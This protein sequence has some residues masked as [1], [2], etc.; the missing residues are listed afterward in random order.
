MT[1]DAQLPSFDDPPVTEVVVALSFRPLTQL[2]VA[3]LG[4][5]WQQVLA[6]T[7]PHIEERPPYEPPVERFDGPVSGGFSLRVGS[8][9]PPPRL[10]FKSADDQE[11]LQIQ[12]DW[13]ACNWRKVQPTAK[14][15]RW[16][17]RR[18]AFEQWFQAFTAFLREH[19]V[20]E[21]KPVQCE[22]TYIN[23]IFPNDAWR[24]HGDLDRVLT[25]VERA[26]DFL[27]R[28]Q[29]TTL[30]SSYVM[31]VDGRPQ[32]RFHVQC[33][34]VLN[35]KD[36]SPAVLLNLT[37]RGNP[38]DD[39][40]DGMMEF[41]DMGREWIVQGFKALTTSEMHEQWGLKR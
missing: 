13:F 4:M 11:L 29:E 31:E 33:D 28:P 17:S 34:P 7:F 36:G 18:R 37:A 3:H 27:P 5:L 22:V 24:G 19:N 21:L 14:Y 6:D 1:P 32:G 12:K 10:W 41:F 39:S 26:P 23:H 15:G 40:M 30:R 25:V 35:T 8:G 9:P 20:G 16:P 2:T 38:L